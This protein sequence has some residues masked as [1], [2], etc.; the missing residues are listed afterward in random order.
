[1]YPK[2]AHVAGG[3]IESYAVGAGSMKSAAAIV[4]SLAVVALAVVPAASS[5]RANVWRRL[6]RPLR[7]SSLAPGATCPV[8]QVDRRVRWERQHIYGT[9]GTGRGPVYPG[10]GGPPVGEVTVAPDMQYGGQWYGAKVF[11]YVRP[12]YQGP[13]LIRGRQLDGGGA[14]GFNGQTVPKRELHIRRGQTVYWTGQVAGSRG[15]PSDIR[16]LQPGCYGVQIDGTTFS[17][18]VIFHVGT[19]PPPA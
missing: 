12:R 19:P 17:R 7:L 15:V 10:L 8:S 5:Q 6:H 18:I 16:V 14:L 11:W 1:M 13:A 3:A 4:A 2:A 9:A